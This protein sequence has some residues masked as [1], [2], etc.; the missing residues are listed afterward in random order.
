LLLTPALAQAPAAPAPVQQENWQAAAPGYAWS[1]PGD[2]QAHPG[3]RNEWWYC[4][5]HLQAA[6]GKRFAYQFTFFRV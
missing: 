1:F 6:D 3:F 2:Q 4:T 5:G